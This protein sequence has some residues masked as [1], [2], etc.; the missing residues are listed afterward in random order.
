VDVTPIRV[1]GV[2]LPQSHA[3]VVMTERGQR[4]SKA[5]ARLSGC[6]GPIGQPFDRDKYL[7][8]ASVHGEWTVDGELFGNQLVLKNV[9]MTREKAPHVKGTA[10]LR[11][12]DLGAIMHIASPPKHGDDAAAADVRGE[13]WG[14]L[15]VFDLPLMDMANARAQFQI[16]P[17]V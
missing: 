10:Q 17:T 11:G 7:H 4:Q 8:D 15:T 16:A 6:G 14:D 2:P 5:G 3:R 1:R 9:Q 12:L 13:M